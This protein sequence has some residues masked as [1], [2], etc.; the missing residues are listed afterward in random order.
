MNDV[1]VKILIGI[2]CLGI[3]WFSG[4]MTMALAAASKRGDEYAELCTRNKRTDDDSNSTR[5]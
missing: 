1:V 2:S 3:G 5:H 4:A